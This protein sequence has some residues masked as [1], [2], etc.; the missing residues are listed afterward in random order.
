V[1]GGPIEVGGDSGGTREGTRGSSVSRPAARFQGSTGR[2]T[3]NYGPIG[4]VRG[5]VPRVASAS[6]KPESRRW[7]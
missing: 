5:A 4:G 2:Y 7:R 3:G 1:T 6:L